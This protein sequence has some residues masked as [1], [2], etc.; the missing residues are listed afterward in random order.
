MATIPPAV[1]RAVLARDGYRCARRG[2][3]APA[4]WRCITGYR[5]RAAGP[6][7]PDNLVTLCAA[8][9]R[10]R[11]EPRAAVPAAGAGAG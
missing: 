4:S 10:L 7:R 8:C 9:H 5:A 3:P 6:N 1:R 2:A 11:H